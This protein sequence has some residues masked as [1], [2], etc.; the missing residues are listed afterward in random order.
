MEAANATQHESLMTM[1]VNANKDTVNIADVKSGLQSDAFCVVCNNTLIAKKGEI[2]A[3]HFAHT[4]GTECK[5]WRETFIHLA[6]KKYLDEV[7]VIRLPKYYIDDIAVQE[8]MDFMFS[9]CLVEK[10]LDSIV[11]DICLISEN[12]T[13]LIV[14]VA[15]THFCDSVKIEKIKSLGVSCIEIDLSKF[16]DCKSISYQD[17]KY[18]LELGVYV[19]W[20]YHRKITSLKEYISGIKSQ[21]KNLEMQRAKRIHFEK[22]YSDEFTITVK[23][24]GLYTMNVINKSACPAGKLSC[25]DCKYMVSF[26]HSVMFRQF[27]KCAYETRGRY[28]A[29]KAEVEKEKRNVVSDTIVMDNELSELRNKLFSYEHK[30]AKLYAK[31]NIDTSNTESSNL[32][33]NYQNAQKQLTNT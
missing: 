1:A 10:R 22:E 17:I 24:D 12:G 27:V 18:M 23:T 7:K 3:H 5:Y 29:F 33:L 21:I 15:V 9:E 6:V 14:E 28:F 2:K 8:S 11:P 20:I 31:S 19:S 4:N 25:K 16:K 13:K 26:E 32:L 30:L